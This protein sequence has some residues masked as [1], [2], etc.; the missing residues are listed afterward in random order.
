MF[1]FVSISVHWLE[2]YELALEYR[3]RANDQ[4]AR[5]RQKI[6]VEATTSLN[7]SHDG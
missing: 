3:R 1:P 2:F 4:K 7:I 6:T 5:E